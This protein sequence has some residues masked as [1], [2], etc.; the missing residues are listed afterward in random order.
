MRYETYPQEMKR[1][2]PT[3]PWISRP[4]WELRNIQK[5]LSMLPWLNTE[6]DSQRLIEVTEELSLRKQV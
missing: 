1:K 5:A 6:E 2:Y 4:T 3:R